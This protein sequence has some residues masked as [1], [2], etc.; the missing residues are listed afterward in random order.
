M[1]SRTV[2]LVGQPNVGK[3]VVFCHLTGLHIMV[4][5]YPGTTVDFTE[6]HVEIG[7]VHCRLIDAPG[8]YGLQATNEAERVA[9]DLLKQG[10]CVVLCVLDAI[11]LESSLHL[12]LEVLDYDLPTIVLIN[13][14]DLAEKHALQIDHELL[15]DELGVPVIPTVAVEGKGLD[16][17]GRALY[18]MIAPPAGEPCRVSGC[19]GPGCCTQHQVTAQVSNS[20]RGAATRPANQGAGAASPLPD[21]WARAEALA[22]RISGNSRAA[23]E[24]PRPDRLVQPWPGI[25]IALG[26]LGLIF[27]VVIGLG[28]GM[29]RFLLLPLFRGLLFPVIEG[30][31]TALVSPLWLRNVLIG[32][33]GFLIKGLEWP[34]A[35]VL[36]YVFS[37]YLGLSVLEDWGYLPRLG[38]LLDG[39][40]NKIGLSGSCIIPLLLGY[41]CGIPAIMSTRSLSSRKQR[42][43]ISS[44]VCFAVPCVSQTGAFIV[45]LAERSLGAVLLLFL[46]SV[47]AVVSVGAIMDRM[48]PER[49]PY[50]LM[51]VPELLLPK[52]RILLKKV[53]MR[54]KHYVSEGAIPMIIAVAFVSLLY[55]TGVLTLAG[56][57]F[58]P[59]IS[60]WL[61]LP[62]QAV[63]PLVL[64]IVRRELA[65]LPLIDMELTTLQFMTGAVVAL[66][67]V[68]CIA[69]VTTMAKEF[70]IKAALLVL[71]LTTFTALFLGG[72]VAQ[73]GMTLSLLV[74]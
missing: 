28:M 53:L 40:L 41:G 65:V 4:S 11:N 70:G 67:Y 50:T 39:L 25:P 31:V 16:D 57:A 72:L 42:L 34:F 66:F 62:D 64:G 35:L 10:P 51:E 2:L 17:V 33:Y 21:L 12:L 7:G 3:S 30:V 63:V 15:E 48:S 49:A 54:V 36:P 52:P 23:T 69:M 46:L 56:R 61:N 59:L 29:R 43:M 18:R 22:E 5:N 27:A 13:R 38:V 58:A 45:L 37:F 71:L 8:T 1:A 74:A 32:E 9:V 14:Q 68:P 60:G 44:M 55:E 26:V 19:G 47:L 24:A 20:P 73:A 6:G